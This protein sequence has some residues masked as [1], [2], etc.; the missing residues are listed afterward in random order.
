MCVLEI[1]GDE[2]IVNQIDDLEPIAG[3]WNDFLPVRAL[4]FR[5]VDGDHAATRRVQVGAEIEL[6]SNVIDERVVSI[7]VVEQ[8]HDFR[9]GRL[10]LAV[11]DPVASI[12]SLP[13]T[14][15]E[16][17][18]IIGHLAAKPPVERG[19]NSGHICRP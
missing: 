9:V 13:D 14:Y 19:L 17:V 12:R 11:E 3:L 1:F 7:E 4:G 15:D 16:I 2:L 6:R 8:L 10:Q 5:D 18:A